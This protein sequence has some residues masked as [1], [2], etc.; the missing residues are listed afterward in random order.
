MEIRLPAFL[1][2]VDEEEKKAAEERRMERINDKLSAHIPVSAEEMAAWRRWG[3]L[4]PSSCTAGIRRK[5]KKRRKKKLPKASSSSSCCW[6]TAAG[7]QGIMFGHKGGGTEDAVTI[8]YFQRADVFVVHLRSVHNK[9]TGYSCRVETALC[10]VVMEKFIE[11]KVLRGGELILKT[12]QLVL[13]CACTVTART[14]TTSRVFR[15]MLA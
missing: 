1:L 13:P 5:R 7:C 3:K 9:V 12:R 8:E 14:C 4:P 15:E 10:M 11:E 2:G 6:G